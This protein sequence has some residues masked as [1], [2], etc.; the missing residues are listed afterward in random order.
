MCAVAFQAEAEVK[1]K[2]QT[3]AAQ[4]IDKANAAATA[5]PVLVTEGIFAL[6]MPQR[7]ILNTFGLQPA[8]RKWTQ[9]MLNKS[10]AW[11]KL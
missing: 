7:A 8:M 2:D 9:Q 11:T 3:L 4:P 6:S 5:E 10:T 1:L